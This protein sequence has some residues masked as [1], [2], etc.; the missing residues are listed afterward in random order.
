VTGDALAVRDLEVSYGRTSVLAGLTFEVGWGELVAVVGPNGA[1][2]STMF[3][4]I[5]GLV[6]ANGTVQIGGVGC[7]HRRDRMGAAYLPQQSE[8]DLDFPLTVG[9]LVVSGRRRFRPWWRPAGGADRAMASAALERVGLAGFERRPIRA[10]SGGQVQRA[11][12]ARALAQ[13]ARILLLDEALS[14][15]DSPST[16]QLLTLFRSLCDEGATILLAT[17]D[18]ALARR[19]FSRCL[20]VRGTIQGDGPPEVV[21]GAEVLDRTFGSASGSA[22][23]DPP[24]L[25][26]G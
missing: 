25:A 26:V 14:G 15:V 8:V 18:L 13:Q 20:A 9:E 16:E 17:H 5:C 7:H 6:P 24:A 2:K 10:L 12:L 1:G 19:R 22:V 4:A 11:F 3:K 21:L 23:V